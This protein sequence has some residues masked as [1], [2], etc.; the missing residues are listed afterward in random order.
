MGK[1]RQKIGLCK[2]IKAVHNQQPIFKFLKGSVH[3]NSLLGHFSYFK[4]LKFAHFQ[5]G[6][7]VTVPY[8]KLQKSLINQNPEF[9][10]NI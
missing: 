1:V 2:T 5:S 10:N 7:K 6:F 8:S 3:R 9:T 4:M